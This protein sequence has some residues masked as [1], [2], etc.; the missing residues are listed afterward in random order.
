MPA[1]D[2][3]LVVIGAGAAGLMAA[4]QAGRSRPGLR[5]TALDGAKRLGAKILIAGGGRCNV[6]HYAVDE[7]AFAGSTPKAI[8]KVLRKFDV[9]ETVAFFQE[10]GVELKREDTGKLFPVTDR[11]QTVLDALLRAA[12]DAGVDLVTGWRVAGVERGADGFEIRAAEASLA[13]LRSR[14][15]ILAT[16][17]KSVP[18]TGSDGSG[19]ELARSLGHSVTPRVFPALV[20]LLLPP[21]HPFTTLRGVSFD[22]GLAVAA[23]GG[24][25]LRHMAGSVLCT[26]FGLSGPAILDVSRY[27]LEARAEDPESRLVMDLLPEEAAEALEEDLRSLG[28][29]KVLAFLRDRLA[30]RLARTMLELAGVPVDRTGSALTREER[31][32]LLQSLKELDLPVTGDRGFRFAEVTAGGVPLRELSLETL[33]SRTTPRLH[34]CGEICDVDGRIGG[35]NFQWAWASGTLAGRGAVAAAE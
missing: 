30:D 29:R 31:R 21:N 8:R 18:K 13:P 19:Y 1:A 15:V 32:R 16:G 17:G 11:A 27:Y 23:G 3:D 35:F 26:H 14:R 5:I 25:R 34:L 4:I 2:H 24:K 28:S 33:E 6:T 20:P 10:L 12:T 7:T 9:A 22:A